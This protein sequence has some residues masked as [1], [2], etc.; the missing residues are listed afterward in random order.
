MMTTTIPTSRSGSILL[1]CLAIVTA[2]MMVAFAFVRAS[3]LQHETSQSEARHML[4]REAAKAG[5]RHA[6]E[7]I[8]ADH[9]Q[10]PIT[11]IEGPIHQFIALHRPYETDYD[12]ERS[13][14][15]GPIMVN[16]NDIPAENDMTVSMGGGPYGWN[17]LANQQHFYDGRGRF[18]EP[19]Y[20]NRPV[21]GFDPTA[22]TLIDAIPFGQASAITDA[23]P[24]RS[25]GN[26]Y[27]AQLRQVPGDARAARMKARYRLRYAAN[28]I[29]L[30][31]QILVNGDPAV[32]YRS[33]DFH[34]PL[35][36][37]SDPAH[38]LTPAERVLRWHHALG[39]MSIAMGQFSSAG[40][41]W[42]L[43][44]N[45][46]DRAAHVFLGRG[47]VL[48]FDIDPSNQ[49]PMSFPYMYRSG[50]TNDFAG[51]TDF[52]RNSSG[53]LAMT[54]GA[55]KFHV[56]TGPQYSFANW[57]NAVEGTSHNGGNANS[58]GRFTPFGR[59]MATAVPERFDRWRGKTD[60]PWN[61]NLMTAPS[62]V[63]F[64]MIAGWMPPGAIR[65]YH[66]E[67]P[68]GMSPSI[69][70][71][72][73][74]GRSFLRELPF[75]R[76]TFIKELSPAWGPGY[77]D[78]VTPARGGI[79]PDYFV[80]DTRIPSQRYPGILAYNGIDNDP[81]GIYGPS[82][83]GTMVHD[84]L[85]RYLCATAHPANL[86]NV[87]GEIDETGRPEVVRGN[88]RYKYQ[89][90]IPYPCQARNESSY[91]HNHNTASSSAGAP[92]ALPPDIPL[93]TTGVTYRVNNFVKVPNPLYPSNPPEFFF[94][95]ATR[96]NLDV[97]PRNPVVPP[98][99]PS[100]SAITEPSAPGW[101][102]DVYGAHPD[103][104]WDVVGQTMSVTIAQVRGMYHQFGLGAGNRVG[105]EAKSAPPG[106][107]F[108][109]Q[110]W[111]GPRATTIRDVDILFVTNLGSNPQRPN[112]P[113]PNPDAW[114]SWGGYIPDWQHR[115]VPYPGANVGDPQAPTWN[116]A[117][118]RTATASCQVMDFSG[119]LIPRLITS[120]AMPQAD[121]G[122]P[123]APLGTYTWPLMAWNH[124]NEPRYDAGSP[125]YSA[126][127]RTAVIELIIND[128]RLSFFGSS[129]DY[130]DDF[131]AL[132]LNGDGK[133]HCSGFPSVGV[134]RERDLGIH[135]YT[136][137]VDAD[138]FALVPVSASF[139]NMGTFH[140]GK[141]RFW[142]V[143]VRGEVWD[144]V[145]RTVVSG[146]QLD[147]VFCIDPMNETQ[148]WVRGG[149]PRPA[150]QYSTHT[151]YQR[152]FFDPYRGLLT[153]HE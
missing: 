16:V 97:D 81:V 70:N 71:G 13:L 123:Q 110:P 17:S 54:A 40:Y 58:I 10:G 24:A 6:M 11:R 128:F 77:G 126:D 67:R 37:N 30:D 106:L 60:A 64:A 4:A 72:R 147:S 25:Q 98:V 86:S 107:F 22:T 78:Y 15:G 31:A 111:T 94:Y 87:G 45:G 139:A 50:G 105:S 119:S 32:D 90:V 19:E 135:Q 9:V 151:I 143:T 120:G 137:S 117:S 138:G 41:G 42:G 48:N 125:T 65:K 149:T 21:V 47:C 75:V 131:R 3:S 152:W 63:I 34:S 36:N 118:L 46:G 66:H 14:P 145:L 28:V 142:R 79:A 124:P 130:A 53:P 104:I 59:G 35:A 33:A 85:G 74:V 26:F 18:Y 122:L 12:T 89:K 5:L 109:G 144:N 129:P 51:I 150:R 76:D 116:L 100:W 38:R 93:W 113:A 68:P 102:N 82:S 61:V 112:D 83:R 69:P 114:M 103:S 20:Q 1:L 153:R 133:A 96:D 23:M 95:K 146:A 2:L 57:D 52:Y 136:T 49:A 84:N 127:E 39:Q 140:L 80:T 141:S 43:D 55:S 44:R 8:I 121:L 27:D 62:G 91:W 108:D 99:T 148:E 88:L 29:D 7:D 73:W 56:L 115:L 134:G 92:P 101:D 132:D